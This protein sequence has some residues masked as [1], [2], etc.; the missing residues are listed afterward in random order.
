MS[1]DNEEI[2]LILSKEGEVLKLLKAVNVVKTTPE[3]WL[4]ELEK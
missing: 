3:K 2:K 4:N 1:E